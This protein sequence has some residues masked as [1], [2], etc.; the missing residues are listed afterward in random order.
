MNNVEKQTNVQEQSLLEQ[1]LHAKILEMEQEAYVFPKR[2]GKKDYLFTLAV[3]VVCLV[4]I[5]A[6]G[7]LG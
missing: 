6:G 5:I 4:G 1:E 7:F 2:M 3:V